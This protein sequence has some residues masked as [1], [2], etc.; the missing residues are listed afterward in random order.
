MNCQAAEISIVDS[1]SGVR[2]EQESCR[3][4]LESGLLGILLALGW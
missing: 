2:L 3:V 1:D 4:T